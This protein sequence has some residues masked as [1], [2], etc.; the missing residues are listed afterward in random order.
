MR[1]LGNNQVPETEI[2]FTP[3]DIENYFIIESLQDQFL[4]LRKTIISPSKM[5]HTFSA[6][7]DNSYAKAGKKLTI[8]KDYDYMASL[9]YLWHA[10]RIIDFAIQVASKTNIDFQSCNDLYTTIE[11][12][13]QESESEDRKVMWTQ[14]H[15]RVKPL[16]NAKLTEF[17]KLCPK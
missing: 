11:K 13:Y 17:R 2:L 4:Y 5:R 8:L 9:K 3:F 16:Y 10:I 14:I 12:I 7:A 1:D 15:Q 6:K